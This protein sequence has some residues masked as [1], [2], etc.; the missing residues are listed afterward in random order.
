MED[1][2]GLFHGLPQL[3]FAAVDDV[4]LLHVGGEAV[5]HIV[6]IGG[7]LRPGL[8]A[9]GEP[10]IE[11]A[12]DGPVDDVHDVPGGPQDHAL[13]AGVGAAAHAEDAGDGAGVHRDGRRRG[14]AFELAHMLVDDDLLLALPGHLGRVG[15]EHCLLQFL[16]TDFRG[17]GCSLWKNGPAGGRGQLAMPKSMSSFS[18]SSVWMGVGTTNIWFSSILWARER[19]SSACT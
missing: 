11:A 18:S 14:P 16:G 4:L 8:V 5:V 2:D 10:G 7:Q 19:Y 3:L 17:H 1:G 9:P 13:A 12:A 15:L 6:G